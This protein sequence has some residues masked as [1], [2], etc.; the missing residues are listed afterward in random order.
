MIAGTADKETLGHELFE[1]MLR[2]AS[3]ELTRAEIIGHTEFALYRIGP[4]V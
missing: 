3:G 2:V 1:L 4:Q